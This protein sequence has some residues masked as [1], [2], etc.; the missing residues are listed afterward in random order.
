MSWI[1][2]CRRVAIERFSKESERTDRCQTQHDCF[3]FFEIKYLNVFFLERN[4]GFY[5]KKK[6]KR[7]Y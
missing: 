3:F 6:K 7:S 5:K 2:V 1:D 4:L